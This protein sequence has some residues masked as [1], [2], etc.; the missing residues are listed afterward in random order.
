MA[1]SRRRRL[2]FLALLVLWATA[3][4][5]RSVPHDRSVAPERRTTI[6]VGTDGGMVLPTLFAGALAGLAVDV[7]LFPVDTLKTRMQCR[8]APAPMIRF[9]PHV[10]NHLSRGWK[11][12]MDFRLFN[13]WSSAART[14]SAPPSGLPQHAVTAQQL[15]PQH[16][17]S[18]IARSCLA[19]G[20]GLYSGFAIAACG[21]APSGALFFVVYHELVRKSR[22]KE[23]TFPDWF[24]H[25]LAAF[26]AEIAA[27]TVRVPCEVV[28]QNMQVLGAVPKAEQH[29]GGGPPSSARGGP[30]LSF[31]PL[32]RKIANDSTSP[33]FLGFYRGFGSTVVRK[34]PWAFVGIPAMESLRA[35]WARAR[36]LEEELDAFRSA[37]CG[38]VASAAIAAATTPLDVVK[39]RQMT[40]VVV[41]PSSAVASPVRGRARRSMRTL[42]LLRQIYTEE[43]VRGL[44]RGAAHRTVLLGVGGFIFFG[45]YEKGL[46]C[47]GEGIWD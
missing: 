47:A 42:P 25:G 29:A 7:A 39:T 3:A 12:I 18:R 20:G 33:G 8:P 24:R 43:G 30:A 26:C 22:S 13:S 45:A 46:R 38:S 21:S 1:S 17:V 37:V 34:V 28:K 27:A 35:A 16:A 9:Q 44:F 4:S 36:G 23:K 6:D 11:R 32:L 40:A 31:L 14:L 2:S 15:R 5:A 10:H 19:G 41:F